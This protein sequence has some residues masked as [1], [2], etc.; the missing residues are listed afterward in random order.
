M[1]RKI[2]STTATALL[3]AC[4]PKHDDG[5][6]TFFKEVAT[7]SADIKCLN[8]LEQTSKLPERQTYAFGNNWVA[9]PGGR[10]TYV[11]EIKI[12]SSRIPSGIDPEFICVADAADMNPIA[13]RQPARTLALMQA[14]E[15]S[16]D[17]FFG[18]TNKKDQINQEDIANTAG[19]STLQLKTSR[20]H[21]RQFLNRIKPQLSYL[22]SVLMAQKDHRKQ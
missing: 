2:S 21:W 13:I 9:F 5:L 4:G 17:A 19:F 8:M 7:K 22:E 14:A 16:Y 12:S 18:H 20:H 11:R 15:K 6:N 1:L 10:P 3:V